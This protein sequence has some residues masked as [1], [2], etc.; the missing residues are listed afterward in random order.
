MFNQPPRKCLNCGAKCTMVK[1]SQQRTKFSLSKAIAGAFVAGPLGTLIGGLI[2]NKKITYKCT[3]CG[4]EQEP[5][6]LI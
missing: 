5:D 3:E 4:F 6:V 2:G 1:A